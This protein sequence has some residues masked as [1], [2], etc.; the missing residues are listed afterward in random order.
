MAPCASRIPA[1]QGASLSPDRAM[2]MAEVAGT[3]P[4]QAQARRERTRCAAL[5]RNRDRPAPVRD[6]GRAGGHPARLPHH[7]R[8]EADPA[9]QYGH[10]G[11]AGLRS[12]GHGDRHGPGDRVAQHRP[13]GGLDR[14]LRRDVVRPAD[15]RLAAERSAS[16]SRIPSWLVALALGLGLGAAIGAFQGFLIAYVGIPSFIVTLG[17]LLSRAGSVWLLSSGA[18]VSGLRRSS[19]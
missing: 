8:R 15:D 9:G 17:G 11:G 2:S 4:G 5:S 1:A 18:A 13:V 14:R 7:V 3:A 6:A 19:S 10:P 12:G 16:R